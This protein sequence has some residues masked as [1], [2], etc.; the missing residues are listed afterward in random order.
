MHSEVT[1]VKGR[2]MV[3]SF[4]MIGQSNMAG[5][6]IV[7]DVPPIENDKI[8]MMRNGLWLRAFNPINPDRRM[9]G[10]C[11]A[12]SFADLYSKDHDVTV[13]LIPCAE[14]GS[15]LDMWEPGGILFD[16]ACYMTE[17]AMR[18]STLAGILWHQGESD[19]SLARYPHC[20]EKLTQIIREMRRKIGI[21]DV[22]FIIGGLGDFLVKS[23]K[24]ERVEKFR[25]YN[26]VNAALIKVASTEPNCGFVSA[27]GLESNSDFL[28]FSSKALREFGERYYKAYKKLGYNVTKTTTTRTVDY[29]STGL[30]H[31]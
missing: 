5:R 27:V 24:P 17:L 6:G 28:H 31:L 26:E 13:G 10:I 30:E 29:E 11:L 2:G 14:G 9:S 18:T 19:S 3:H 1:F 23:P 7:S 25:F 21:S 16:H 8:H 4:L 12:E 15:S 22:P 20:E